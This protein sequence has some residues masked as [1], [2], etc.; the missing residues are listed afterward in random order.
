MDISSLS[1]STAVYQPSSVQSASASQVNR[2]GDPDGDG[3][4]GRVHHGHGRGGQ[5]HQ[6]MMQALQSMGLSLPQQGSNGSSNA[7]DS[8]GDNDGSGAVGS[9]K[10]DMRKFMHALFQAVKGEGS[11]SA[12][13][14]TQTGSGTD[15]KADFAS[16]LSSL[17]S[18]VS[19]GSAPA[20]LQSAFNTLVSDLQGAGSGSSSAASAT[21][22][23]ATASSSVTLQTLLSKLQQNLGY[24][25]SSSAVSTGNV[26]NTQV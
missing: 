7:S 22:T 2:G 20:D 15:P 13:S 10:N 9:V 3:D 26:V 19:N 25:S 23:S 8:D 17:I 1:S 24:G 16:G 12:A 18:Q 6:A 11:S 5:M 14:G 4:G 21:S